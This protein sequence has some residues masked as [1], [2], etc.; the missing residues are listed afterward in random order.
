MT[1]AT[2][3]SSPSPGRVSGALRRGLGPGAGRALAAGVRQPRTPPPWSPAA[4]DADLRAALDA[5]EQQTVDWCEAFEDFDEDVLAEAAAEARVFRRDSG[6]AVH[7][8]VAD[9]VGQLADW[10]RA[11]DRLGK[12]LTA[13]ARARPLPDWAATAA[14]TE[15]ARRRRARQ[16]LLEAIALHHHRGPAPDPRTRHPW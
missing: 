12:T 5:F 14:R 6:A 11:L 8:L 1:S 9:L 13:A 7:Q 15:E 4:V 10:D 16:T 2:T 3:V